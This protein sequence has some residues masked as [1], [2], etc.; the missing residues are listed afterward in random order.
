[1]EYI[2]FQGP[3]PSYEASQNNYI[4]FSCASTNTTTN[5]KFNC[6]QTKMPETSSNDNDHTKTDLHKISTNIKIKQEYVPPETETNEDRKGKL[7]Y[8]YLLT[9]LPC[10]DS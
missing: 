9:V 7:L 5:N 10:N 4:N 6:S 2:L 3:P 8:S 1:M